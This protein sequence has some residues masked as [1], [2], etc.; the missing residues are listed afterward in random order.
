[1]ARAPELVLLILISDSTIVFKTCLHASTT[2]AKQRKFRK[3]KFKTIG[4]ELEQNI[5]AHQHPKK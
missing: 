1:M 4:L 2:R 5:C 3:E